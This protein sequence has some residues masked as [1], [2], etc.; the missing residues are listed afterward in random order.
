M[1]NVFDI[2]TNGLVSM[3]VLNNRRNWHLWTVFRFARKQSPWC[4]NC[5]VWLD[6]VSHLAFQNGESVSMYPFLALSGPRG[7]GKSYEWMIWMM[8]RMVLR[9]LYYYCRRNNWITLFVPSARIWTHQGISTARLWVLGYQVIEM[10]RREG[11]FFAQ[12]EHCQKMLLDVRNSEI[13]VSIVAYHFRS[14]VEDTSF[15]V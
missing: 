9:T 4:R 8:W 6:C 15:E 13:V 12:P 1:S 3:L 10:T 5:M 14:F 11:G 2:S 7:S